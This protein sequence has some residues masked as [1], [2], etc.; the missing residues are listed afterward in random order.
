M[1]RFQ[2]RI[3]KKLL[4]HQFAFTSNPR[5]TRGGVGRLRR[6]T[7]FAKRPD[8]CHGRQHPPQPHLQPHHRR[9]C[10]RSSSKY[11]GRLRPSTLCASGSG[12]HHGLPRPPQPSLEPHRWCCPN[13]GHRSSGT[14][15]WPYSHSC[16]SSNC[17]RIPCPCTRHQPGSLRL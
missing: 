1:L 16:T 12:K 15:W 10:P 17:R 5:C 8:T 2:L 6:G 11:F 13:I 9:C 3:S 7:R 14:S 4:R